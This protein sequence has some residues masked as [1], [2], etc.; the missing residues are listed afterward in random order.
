M[1]GVT[2]QDRQ[3]IT[4]RWAGDPF[5]MD[6]IADDIVYLAM[7][8]GWVRAGNGELDGL[9]APFAYGASF[10]HVQRAARWMA[11]NGVVVDALNI[12]I[13]DQDNPS[14]SN[15]DFYQLR[16]ASLDRFLRTGRP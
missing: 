7:T 1:F 4:D 16:G 9:D 10:R 6:R 12:E 15:G 13:M 14:L 5:A 2:D 3:A 11:E 8:R